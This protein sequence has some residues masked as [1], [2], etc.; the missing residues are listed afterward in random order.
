M[1]KLGNLS[2]T[3]TIPIFFLFKY[4]YAIAILVCPYMIKPYIHLPKRGG[5]FLHVKC[6]AFYIM[7]CCPRV[8]AFLK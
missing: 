3:Y 6:P 4:M 8:G 1:S 5:G 2:N 7:Q